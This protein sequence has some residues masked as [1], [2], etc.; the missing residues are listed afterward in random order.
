M[1][2][3]TDAVQ[4]LDATHLIG[5][6]LLIAVLVISVLYFAWRVIREILKK[7]K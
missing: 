6:S 5:V 1:E 7:N 4:V 2:N 3:I